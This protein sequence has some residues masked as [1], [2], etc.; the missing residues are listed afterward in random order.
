MNNKI[1][2]Y[3]A[4]YRRILNRMGYY[5]YQQGFI[6]R[7]L[8][9]DKGWDD[10]LQR[11]REFILKAVDIV[12]PSRVTVLGSGW[13]LEV[14]LRELADKGLDICLVDIVHPPEVIKQTAGLKNVSIHEEDLSGGLI[15]EVW[16]SAGSRTF[17]NRLPSLE[18]LQIPEYSPDE[19]PGLVISLNILTQLETLPEKLL[20]SKSKATDEEFLEL[21]KGIQQKH[22]KFLQKNKSLLITDYAEVFTE[23][24]GSTYEKP[25]VVI[26][27]PEGVIHEEWKWDFDL[28]KSDYN[29]KRSYLKVRA[30]LF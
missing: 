6:F 28:L 13:L 17:L 3:S 15:E 9:Q 25:T 2:S 18:G 16:K 23:A 10:H 26:N 22:L 19:D 14:P 24:N 11:C 4:S 5:D 21:R 1:M 12:K 30:L 8:N 29:K 20:R 27:L 7:H